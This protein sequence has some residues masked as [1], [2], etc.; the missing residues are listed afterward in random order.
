[1]YDPVNVYCAPLRIAFSL[2]ASIFQVFSEPKE[3]E[4]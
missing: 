4:E 2:I 3:I 1:M